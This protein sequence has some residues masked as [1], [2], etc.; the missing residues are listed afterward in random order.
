VPRVQQK[1]P[2]STI[3]K[4]DILTGRQTRRC[5]A[6]FAKEFQG[7]SLEVTGAFSITGSAPL[8]VRKSTK[9]S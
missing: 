1:E 4:T 3:F 9:R 2:Q 7:C 5:T 8:P 6:A